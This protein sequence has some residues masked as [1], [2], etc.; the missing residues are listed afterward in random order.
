MV[1]LNLHRRRCLIFGYGNEEVRAGVTLKYLGIIIDSWLKFNEHFCYVETKAAK[2]NGALCLCLISGAPMKLYIKAA[3]CK[4]YLVC[5]IV[6]N[7][8]LER[9]IVSLPQGANFIE[10]ASQGH[11]HSGH[12][13]L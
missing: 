4:N 8:N 9:G 3:I 11:S 12:I 1:A 2:V 5:Y 7:S 6:W 13:G 10:Q